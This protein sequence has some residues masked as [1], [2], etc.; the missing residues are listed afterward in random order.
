MT[1]LGATLYADGGL[2]KELN[3]KLGLAWAD[4]SKLSRLWNHA[5]L[6]RH[7]KI[8]IYKSVVISRLLYGLNTAWLNIAEIRRLN[9][10]HCRCLR[11]ILRIPPSFISRVPN[12]DILAHAEEVPLGRQLLKQQLLLFGRLIRAPDT[13]PLR[14]LTFI[15]ET[16][17]L[18]SSICAR[19]RG[20][21]RNEWVLMLQKKCWNMGV[22]YH[23]N[24]YVENSWRRV[25]ARYCT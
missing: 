2:K 22:N 3:R 14:S 12:A 25:I 13:D 10:F 15:E 5:S 16:T 17:Q 20:K 21:P 18:K 8:R 7:R 19:R 11:T 24:V 23:Q 6:D 4:F 1:Y 9:G